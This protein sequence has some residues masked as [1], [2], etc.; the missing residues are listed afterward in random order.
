[1]SLMGVSNCHLTHGIAADLLSR[2][3]QDFV[4]RSPELFKT[5]H[6]QS[7][8]AMRIAELERLAGQLTL[9]LSAAKCQESDVTVPRVFSQSV[10]GLKAHSLRFFKVSEL[11]A[12]RFC[13]L[14]GDHLLS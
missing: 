7:A 13:G 2:W 6:E 3:K 11:N 14:G 12:L 5:K 9:E 8:E 1:M 4:R 10:P